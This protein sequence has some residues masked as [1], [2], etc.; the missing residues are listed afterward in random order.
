MITNLT[1]AIENGAALGTVLERLQ[2]LQKRDE[3]QSELMRLESLQKPR[4]EASE[5]S[6]AMAEFVLN[7]DRK[8]ADVPMEEK[9]D[10]MK[11]CNSRIVVN[12]DRKVARIY[13][14]RVPAVNGDLEAILEGERAN[15]RFVS[16]ES[17]R[18]GT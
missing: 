7:F 9:K 13:V 1:T 18:R 8:F 12:K 16:R 17:A 6:K 2:T 3:L 5:V 4:V 11:K 10:L 15:P 14:R